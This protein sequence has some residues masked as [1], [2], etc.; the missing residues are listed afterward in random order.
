[1]NN[2]IDLS[3]QN[4]DHGRYKKKLKNTGANAKEEKIS[5][6]SEDFEAIFLQ[7]MLKSMRDTVPD[8]GLTN[9]GNGE[10]VFRSMLD[11]EYAKSMASQRF[12]GVA[13]AIERTLLD[14][15]EATGAKVA[16]QNVL[17][18]YEQSTTK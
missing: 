11:S 2:K 12:S 7:L 5:Q 4:T 14:N 1:M 16:R 10:D 17:Q 13:D 18:R 8:N 3:L 6:L 15:I 9:G